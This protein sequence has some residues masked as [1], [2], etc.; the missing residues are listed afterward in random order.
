M[1][2]IEKCAEAIAKLE[3]AIGLYEGSIELIEKGIKGPWE[4]SIRCGMDER[5]SAQDVRKILPSHLSN[6]AP[7]R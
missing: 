5:M 4:N 2:Y 6:H 7:L 1:L 3:G